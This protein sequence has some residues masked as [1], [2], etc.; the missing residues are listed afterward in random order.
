MTGKNKIVFMS[1][2]LIKLIISVGFSSAEC[3]FKKHFGQRLET[4]AVVN[5]L[6]VSG[7]MDCEKQ[8]LKH[9]DICRA[10]NVINV[11]GNNYV[12]EIITELPTGFDAKDLLPNPRGKFIIKEGKL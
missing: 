4:S 3:L 11:K 2:L 1:H 10:A 6:P 5:V 8:C 12:C 7:V 9:G